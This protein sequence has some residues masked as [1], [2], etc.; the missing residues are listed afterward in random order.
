MSDYLSIGFITKEEN[1]ESMALDY[2]GRVS[3]QYGF[4]TAS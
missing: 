1:H 4:H 3:L 2:N